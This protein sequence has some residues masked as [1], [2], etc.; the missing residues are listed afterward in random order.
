MKHLFC[1]AF[2]MAAGISQAAQTKPN[3][4]FILADDLGYGDVQCLNPQGKIPTPCLDKLARQGLVFTDAHSSSAVCS[5]TRY[6]LLTGRYNWRSRLKSGVLG[7]MSPR[8]IEPGRTTVASFLQQQGYYTGC[9]G[10]WHLGMDWTLK[11]AQ[12]GFKD[13][14]EKGQDGW[15]V[16]FSRPIVNGPNSVGFNYYFGISASLDMVPYTF[17]ENNRVIV[18][19]SED[20]AFPM[21]MG[22]PKSSTRKGPGAAGFEAVEVLPTLTSQAL[23]FIRRQSIAAKSGRPFFL[24]LPLASPHTPI[25]P[26]PAW[27]GRSGLNPYAD[28][29]METD[30]AVGSVLEALEREGLAGNT[31]VFFSSDNG[32]S[33]EAKYPELL[34]KGH[35]PSYRFRG[36]KADIFEGGHRVPFLVRWP[37]HIKPGSTSSQTI[38]LMD[39]FA[40]CAEILGVKLP[41]NA[42]EDSVSI[43]PAL[44]GRDH[45]PLREALVHHSINGSF[46]IRQGEWKLE[47]CPDSGGWSAPTPGSQ[48]AQGLPPVQLYNL[49]ADLAEQR[50]LQAEHPDKV[51]SLRRLLEKYVEDGRSTPGAPQ[52]NTGTVNIRKP[53]P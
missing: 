46:A 29:V 39:L 48:A 13:N 36:T 10:K 9:I 26:S 2:L 14:I 19:P 23:E 52:S 18:Q 34:P 4:V 32:C 37:G 5:P 43:L 40:T 44:E 7:G 27:R 49:N 38:C 30:A 20:K 8:L 6:S 11:S 45:Q 17:I 47:L 24:Y 41:D 12:S 50:N 51:A 16:D 15:R 28:F 1:L 31:L 3:I 22:R 35:N 21:M 25:A 33:P 42:A 53:M